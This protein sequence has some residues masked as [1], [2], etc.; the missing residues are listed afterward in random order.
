MLTVLYV[1]RAEYCIVIIFREGSRA[2]LEARYHFLVPIKLLMNNLFDRLDLREQGLR[3]WA[4]RWQELRILAEE[5]PAVRITCNES[6]TPLPLAR[7]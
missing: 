5:G 1:G 3:I 7:V 6:E 4:L 2:R